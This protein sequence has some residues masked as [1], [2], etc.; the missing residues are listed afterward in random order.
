MQNAMVMIT[1]HPVTVA[2]MRDESTIIKLVWSL[3][4]CL[5][6]ARV[7][8]GAKELNSFCR[9]KHL[10]QGIDFQEKDAKFHLLAKGTA[11][12]ALEAS[13]AIVAD[14]SKPE[15]TQTGVKKLNIKAQPLSVQ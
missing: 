4:R 3:E 8:F 13:S 15:T 5:K 12:A 11:F 7:G 9:S 6:E 14:D 10:A 2:V 1:A